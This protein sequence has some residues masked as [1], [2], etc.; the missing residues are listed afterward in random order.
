M[1]E[2]PYVCKLQVDNVFDGEIEITLYSGVTILVGSN[3][4]GKTQT[5]KK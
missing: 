2:Y 5:L 4:S 3:G 1:M